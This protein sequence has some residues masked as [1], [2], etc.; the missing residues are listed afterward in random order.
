MSVQILTNTLLI[1]VL[2]VWISTRQLSWRAVRVDSVW[3]FPAILAIVGVVVTASQYG[4]LVL[5][6]IDVA[7]VLVEA[8]AA[9]AVGIAMGRIAMLRSTGGTV[10]TR[11]GWWGVALWVV[12]IAVRVGM[13]VAAARLGSDL[14]ASTGLIIVMIAVNRFARAAVLVHRLRRDAAVEVEAARSRV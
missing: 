8:A 10:E 3:R 11:T 13:D 1:A 9:V 7:A 12:F 6:P 2:L 4:S 5:A 14:A